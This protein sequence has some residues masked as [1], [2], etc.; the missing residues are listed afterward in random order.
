MQYDDQ[1]K[2]QGKYLSRKSAIM[3]K[4]AVVDYSFQE[5]AKT[6]TTQTDNSSG[7]IVFANLHSREET[8]GLKEP[9]FF[10]SNLIPDDQQ[11]PVILAQDFTRDWSKNGQNA[12]RKN[13]FLDEEDLDPL[14]A[15]RLQQ[16]YDKRMQVQNEMEADS[17]GEGSKIHAKDSL[18]ES[19]EG[20]GPRNSEMAS[21]D[22]M[23]KVITEMKVGKK[24]GQNGD[25][26]H[27]SKEAGGEIGD[28]S[29]IPMVGSH[30]QHGDF[31]ES[32]RMKYLAQ[33][34][35]DE[36]RKTAH[37]EAY[38]DAKASLDLT[39]IAAEARSVGYEA[40][41]KEGEAKGFISADQKSQA[42]ALNIQG[43]LAEFEKLKYNI[44]ENAQENFVELVQAICE[45]V[46]DQYFTLDQDAFA[47]VILQA[48]KSG[49]QADQFVVHVHP[50]KFE[51]MKRVSIP[52]FVDKLKSDAS[53]GKDEFKVDSDLTALSGNIRQMITD[54]LKK[55]D[56]NL[57]DVKAS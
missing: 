12:S 23:S 14:E 48:I 29:F 40:G 16:I 47:K 10:S 38:A 9:S 19:G 24:P 11:P 25:E 26:E 36:I 35:L 53:L 4:V 3:K 52:G 51:A 56:V 22:M 33:K 44:M 54:L 7:N 50:E 30:S 45:A 21:I 6:K 27:Q 55:A 41:F 13:S 49:I 31:E 46:L 15:L 20:S 17:Q 37:L 57:F 28:S 2:K 8:A 39:K 18:G 32:A 42:V 5:I 34:E 1:D 43:L